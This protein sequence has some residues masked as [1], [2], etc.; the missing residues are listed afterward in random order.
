MRFNPYYY[1]CSIKRITQKM[2]KLFVT[3]SI[4]IIMDVVLKEE[5]IL[6]EEMQKFSFNPYY[7][8]CSIKRNYALQ[9]ANY[10]FKFQ[11]IIRCNVATHS[12]NMLPPNPV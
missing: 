11:C 7:Y 4:L 1:G 3:V 5:L 10:D 8:G 2:K 9:K 12:G 6:K